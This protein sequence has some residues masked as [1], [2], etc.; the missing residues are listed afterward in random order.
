[1][2]IDSTT[3]VKEIS[4][5]LEAAKL[6]YPG[7]WKTFTSEWRE[8]TSVDSIWLTYS[9]NYLLH[10][11]GVKWA[12]DPFSLSTR[13]PGVHQPDFASDLDK[14][15]L[16]VLTHEHNDHLDLNL[17]RAVRDI[18]ITWIIPGYLQGRVLAAVDLPR[19][20]I[21]TPVNGC[22]IQYQDLTLTPFKA[23]HIH[24]KHGV[25]ETGYL[26]EFNGKRWLFL[27][28][29]RT[30]DST[31]LP[32]FGILD[33]VFAHLWLGKASALETPPPM[34][35]EFCRFFFGFAARRLVVTHM[36]EYGR[37][38]YDLW[39]L[40]HYRQVNDCFN[41]KYNLSTEKAVMGEHVTL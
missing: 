17:V 20:R 23:L 40:E 9:A 4:A 16:V 37:D 12:I 13:V 7:L 1:M 18:P 35:E 34:I 3:R 31:A 6:A 33:G 25:P 39:T 15:S 14:L 41:R 30:Y 27:G 22:P 29:T 24:G 2:P 32:D 38:E 21:I 36:Y 28:D 26:A 11:A 19:E 5:Q 8:E 10:T